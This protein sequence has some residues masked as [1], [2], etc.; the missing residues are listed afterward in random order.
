MAHVARAAE[1]VSGIGRVLEG[2]IVVATAMYVIT[3]H[4]NVG[5]TRKMHVQGPPTFS[6][7][8]RIL[9]GERDLLTNRLMTLRLEDGRSV[10]FSVRKGD[11]AQA[12]YDIR[13]IQLASRA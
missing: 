13:V 6:G 11:A 9:S 3:T 12:T 2:N 7:A 4:Q 10:V 8:I 5:F 1:S